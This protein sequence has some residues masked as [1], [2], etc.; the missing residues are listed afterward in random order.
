MIIR[1]AD[2]NTS[3][4]I[5]SFIQSYIHNIIIDKILLFLYFIPYFYTFVS[6]LNLYSCSIVFKFLNVTICKYIFFSECNPLLEI[7]IIM[8]ALRMY[9]L[10]QRSNDMETFGDDQK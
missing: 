5:C 3:V 7:I 4:I 10:C 6:I 2:E 8:E 9:Y 1:L